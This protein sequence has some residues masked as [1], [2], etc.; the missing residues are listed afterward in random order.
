MT[1]TTDRFRKLVIEHLPIGPSQVTHEADF[2]GDLGCDSLDM[3]ELTMAAEEEFGVEISDDEA[4]EI[5]TFG[6]AV[7]LIDRKLAP[8]AA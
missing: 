1:T 7:A 4:A 8:V 2:H 6:S 5:S 3:V